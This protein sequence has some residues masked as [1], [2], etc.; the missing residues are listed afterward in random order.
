MSRNKLSVPLAAR[1]WDY[2]CAGAADGS[3]SHAPFVTSVR[4]ISLR[5][6]DPSA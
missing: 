2:R 3:P 6:G 5:A 1:M 4:L